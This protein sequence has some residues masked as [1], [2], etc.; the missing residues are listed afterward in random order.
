MKVTTG[1]QSKAGSE[2]PKTD[3]GDNHTKI[4]FWSQTNTIRDNGRQLNAGPEHPK[5]NNGGDNHTTGPKQIQH[6]K[7]YQ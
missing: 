4:E 7:K 3:E 5:T 6:L 1:R 2:H